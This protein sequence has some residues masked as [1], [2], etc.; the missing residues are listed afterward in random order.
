[1]TPKGDPPPPNKKQNDVQKRSAPGRQPQL[2]G[3]D[4]ECLFGGSMVTNDQFENIEV[5]CQINLF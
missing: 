5:Q 4:P 3:L 2:G 1:M